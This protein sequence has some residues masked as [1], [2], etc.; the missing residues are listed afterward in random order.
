[1]TTLVGAK[2]ENTIAE[3]AK[4]KQRAASGIT[5]IFFIQGP[6]HLYVL[7][8]LVAT[9]SSINSS[10]SNREYLGSILLKT[11]KAF[12]AEVIQSACQF[13]VENL[14]PRRPQWT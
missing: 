9:R 13:L 8:A 14:H 12:P 2:A 6:F 11:R 3:I 4:I 10:T 5:I 7:I 1:M